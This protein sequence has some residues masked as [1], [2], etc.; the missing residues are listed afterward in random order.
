MNFI[1]FLVPA[2]LNCRH[3]KA[4]SPFRKY[5]DLGKCMK[6]NATLYA[7]VARADE[8]LCGITGRWFEP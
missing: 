7:E 2:C 1:L 4:Y 5:D 8:K 3:Y 6:I